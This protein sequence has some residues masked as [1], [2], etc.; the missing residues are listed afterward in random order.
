MLSY[1]RCLIG[2][3]RA[4]AA[5]TECDE[6]TDYRERGTDAQRDAKGREGE[7]RCVYFLLNISQSCCLYQV[8]ND[9]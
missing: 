6:A 4:K 2:L 1:Y 8:M 3:S 7:S 5:T 9:P